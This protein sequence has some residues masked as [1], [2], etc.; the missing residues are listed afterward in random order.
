MLV[1]LICVL[2]VVGPT[3]LAL[4]AAG[5]TF[6]GGKPIAISTTP[7]TATVLD[8]TVLN[9]ST[10]PAT[11]TLNITNVNVPVGATTFPLVPPPRDGVL[12][13]SDR[14]EPGKVWKPVV[15]LTPASDAITG[16]YTAQ[17]VVYSTDGSFDRQD[18]T[19]TVTA[20]SASVSTASP[21]RKS[22]RPSEPLP[23]IT[24]AS[25]R[26]TWPWNDTEPGPPATV[27]LD[28]DL[29]VKVIPGALIS[30]EGEPATVTVDEKGVLTAQGNAAGSYKGS[31]GRPAQGDEKAPA[32]LTDV[33]LNIR[34]AWI[35]P[36][37]FLLAGLLLAIGVEWLGTDFLPGIVLKGHLSEQRVRAEGARSRREEWLGDIRHP[38]ANPER[39][40]WRIE[41]ESEDGRRPL[42]T[43][44]I[45]DAQEDFAATP[46][47]EKRLEKWGRRGTETAKIDGLVTTYEWI[48][49]AQKRINERDQALARLI[50]AWDPDLL[51]DYDRSGFKAEVRRTL[52]GGV[53]LD[54]P[55]LDT[56]KVDVKA[57]EDLADLMKSIAESL[58]G[59]AVGPDEPVGQALWVRLARTGPSDVSGIADLQKDVADFAGSD[60]PVPP[61]LD[62]MMNL[63]AFGDDLRLGAFRAILGSTFEPP[64]SEPLLPDMDPLVKTPQEL[65]WALRTWNIVFAITVLVSI[66]IVAMGTEYFAKDTFG[67]PGDYMRL[68]AWGF[69]GTAGVKLLGHLVGSASGL[70]RPSAP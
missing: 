21:S 1:A 68:L 20:P 23:G 55:Q 54:G 53:I 5:A 31:I 45:L 66:T 3:V 16:P 30:A 52:D 26:W 60:R 43:Q 6:L 29:F 28:P 39:R 67:T 27:Q 70:L 7:G 13:T 8:V 46:S 41:G 34:D 19:L 22:G 42:L 12:A 47:I 64:A 69:V 62:V 10:S 51:E 15:I 32:K 18:I 65:R 58:T 61:S 24:L 63:L 59:L 56:V 9:G 57:V 50:T 2:A 44:S 25:E 48:L 40:T 36:F 14:V 4:E 17:L 37:L 38:W 49:D 35:W 33:T 11:F